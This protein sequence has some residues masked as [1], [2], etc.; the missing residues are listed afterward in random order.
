MKQ[1]GFIKGRNIVEN[2]LICQ[3]LVRLYNKKS[4]S[5]RYLIKIDLRKA[6]DTVEWCFFRQML[7]AMKFPEKFINLL[8][9]CVTTPSYSLCVNGTETSIMW[10]LR[11]FATFSIASGLELNKDKYDIYF[12]E[13]SDKSISNLLQVSGF[14]RGCL[15]FRYIRVPISSKKLTKNEGMKLL[16]RIVARIRGWGTR[17]LSY[18]GRLVLVNSILASLHSYWTLIFLIPNGLMKRID[19]YC[20]NF[21]WGGKSKYKKAPNVS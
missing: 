12:N 2:V 13:V 6:Y 9:T 21:L 4:A 1:M 16:D 17:H 18:A 14:K 10:L 19:A 5:L 3:D 8:M 15:P 11:G 7:N 20:R